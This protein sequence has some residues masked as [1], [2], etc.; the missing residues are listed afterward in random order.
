MT[1]ARRLDRLGPAGV[2]A[3][4]ILAAC[5]A[6]YASALSPALQQA[7][8]QRVALDRLRYSAP[9]SPVAATE[10]G[11]DLA[12]FYALFPPAAALTGQVEALHRL[13]RHAGLEAAQGE[14]RLERPSRGL[15]AYRIALP[16]RGTYPQMRAFV[17]ALLAELPTAS[18]D[19]LRLERGRAAD[20]ELTGEL[21]L[22]LHVR[23]TGAVP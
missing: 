23:P 1:L 12:R 5:A 15:W 11:E 21:R 19:A 8:E 17:D 2:A 6:F 20:V 4:G 22:T 7:S 10:S 3:V 18:I 13:A 16:L 14:Y 9:T